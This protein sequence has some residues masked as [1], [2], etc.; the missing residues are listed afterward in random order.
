M[1]QSACFHAIFLKF[2]G[3]GDRL[4]SNRELIGKQDFKISCFR[5]RAEGINEGLVTV[6]YNVGI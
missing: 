3:R 6:G 1:G 2:N 4:G 5:S